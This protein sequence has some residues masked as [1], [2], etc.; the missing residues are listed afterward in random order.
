MGPMT[1]RSEA[2]AEQV[3]LNLQAEMLKALSKLPPAQA[4]GVACSMLL[5]ASYHHPDMLRRVF[6][7]PVVRDGFLGNVITGG[8]H[9]CCPIVK[10]RSWR[11]SQTPSKP[12][13]R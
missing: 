10:E 5:A 13:P 1:A 8:P 11:P 12:R 6:N 4:I 7:E 2:P 9:T 3:N